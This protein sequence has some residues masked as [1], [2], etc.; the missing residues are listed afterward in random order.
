MLRTITA[1][2]LAIPLYAC[3]TSTPVEPAP[4]ELIVL[5]H[6]QATTV[7][8]MLRVALSGPDAPHARVI[9][10]ERT[11]SLL[12]QSDPADLPYVKDLIALLD[13]EVS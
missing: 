12:I 6:A 2:A 8:N 10:D 7:A 5:E 4:F 1:V 13:R 9:A 3:A 11:N